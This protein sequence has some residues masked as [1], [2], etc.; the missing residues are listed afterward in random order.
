MIIPK[1][2]LENKKKIENFWFGFSLGV[3]LGGVS[4]FLLGT[5]SG[6]ELLRRLLHSAEEMEYYLEN[7]LEKIE[8]DKKEE[9]NK[10]KEAQPNK[11]TPL[12]AEVLEKI[13]LAT[14]KN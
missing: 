2:H 8:T 6:R 3:L 5:K 7:Y 13:H 4:L 12:I 10:E 1:T 9:K 14:K 11:R